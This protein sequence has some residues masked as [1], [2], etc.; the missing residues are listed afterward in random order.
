MLFRSGLPPVSIARC[1]SHDLL[2]Q[3][4]FWCQQTPPSIS[5]DPMLA[6]LRIS[7]VSSSFD[8]VPAR[9]PWLSFHENPGWLIVG[10]LTS[11][12]YYKTVRFLFRIPTTRLTFVDHSKLYQR[13][14][15]RSQDQCEI[16]LNSL[17]RKARE[18]RLENDTRRT[19]L[20]SERCPTCQA[21]INHPTQRVPLP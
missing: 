1:S 8:P 12:N 10:Y 14:I 9:S 19:I 16:R 2:A 5:P 3:Y 7:S 4:I 11:Y 6:P 20:R 17:Q 13:T 15:A 18:P 21:V